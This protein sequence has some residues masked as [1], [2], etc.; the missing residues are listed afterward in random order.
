MKVAELGEAFGGDE[1]V[2]VTRGG[3]VSGLYVPLEEGETLSR[4]LRREL[5]GVLGRHISGSLEA[6]GISEEEI[7]EDFN[8]HRR[9]RR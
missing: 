8:A 7:Q 4:E 2:L 6:K 3:R 5:I 1:P 9:S